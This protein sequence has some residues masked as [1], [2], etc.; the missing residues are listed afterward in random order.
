VLAAAKAVA[1]DGGPGVSSLGDKVLV[2]YAWRQYEKTYGPLPLERFKQNL[3]EVN[4]NHLVLAR[5]DLIPGERAQ[6]FSQSEVRTGASRY[7]YIRISNPRDS[8]A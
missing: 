2:H 7:H 5:E 4:G 1:C 3:S 6:E 8:H